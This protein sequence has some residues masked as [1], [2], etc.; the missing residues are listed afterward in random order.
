MIIERDPD[1]KLFSIDLPGKSLKTPFFFPS[2][3]TVKTNFQVSEYFELLKKSGYPG[4]LVS[5]YDLF[6]SKGRQSLCKEISELTENATFTF[7]D[8]GNYESY[9]HR[10]G[11]WNIDNYMDVLKEISIDFAFSFDVFWKEKM[12][13]NDYV[14]KVIENTAT[15]TSVQNMGETVPIIHGTPEN[16][17]KIALKVVEGINPQIIGV[18]ERELGYDLF[19]RAENLKNIRASLDDKERDVVIHLLGT[20]NPISLLVY[21]LCGADFFDALEW[22]TTVARPDNGH[23]YHF[24]QGNIF[25]CRCKACMSK[26]EYPLKTM[27]HNLIFYKKFMKELRISIENDSVNK[28]LERYVPQSGIS[29]VKKIVGLK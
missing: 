13:I 16:L 7:I 4:F 20:G 15:T 18:T 22:C 8:S 6:E 28:L 27:G 12:K 29:K 26:V 14:Q 5:A 9:W 11:D 19:E 2:I 21:S 10:D 25:N 3:S 1:T 24:A 23:L 17:P